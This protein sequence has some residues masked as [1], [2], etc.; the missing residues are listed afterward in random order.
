MD[1]VHL[2]LQT[3]IETSVGNYP[4][5]EVIYNRQIVDVVNTILQLSLGD[6]QNHKSGF[7]YIENVSSLCL[8]CASLF[9]DYV[10]CLQS[11]NL[12]GSAVELIEAM[13]EET[14]SHTP[15]LAKEIAGSLDLAA[16]YDTIEDFYVLMNDPLVKADS[17]DDEAERGLFRAYHIIAHLKDYGNDLRE[18]SELVGGG[19]R[20]VVY[21]CSLFS[22]AS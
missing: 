4:N 16:V 7:K 15:H 11:V 19:S 6:Y 2:I 22:E 8:Q 3:L 9:S 12:K 18:W 13:L 5:Q 21:L 14:S 1:L 20:N 10:I 17:Y